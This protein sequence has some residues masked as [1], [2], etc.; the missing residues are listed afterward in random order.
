[1]HWLILGGMQIVDF[2]NIQLFDYKAL[3]MNVCEKSA[4]NLTDRVI[5]DK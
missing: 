3:V 4:S 2:Y 1:M 5:H